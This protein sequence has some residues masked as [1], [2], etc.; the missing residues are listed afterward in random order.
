MGVTKSPSSVESSFQ[1]S[2]CLHCHVEQ[3]QQE[4]RVIVLF[5][6]EEIRTTLLFAH[7]N[8]SNEAL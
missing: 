5:I 1:R 6:T 7:L 8:H 2:K 4:E 3:G